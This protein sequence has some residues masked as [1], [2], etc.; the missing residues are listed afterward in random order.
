[1]RHI[2]PVG[3]HEKFVASGQ[4]EQA[5][6]SWSIHQFPDEAQMIRLDRDMRLIDGTSILIEAWRSPI[7]EGGNIERVDVW[8]F[9]GYPHRIQQA[10]ARYFIADGSLEVSVQ[11]NQQPQHTASQ[12]F[13]ADMVLA[14]DLPV[15]WGY[16]LRANKPNWVSCLFDFDDEHAFLPMIHAK[17]IHL[18]GDD[19]V[20][21]GET[22]HP[23]QKYWLD[24]HLV[25]IDDL[26]VVLMYEGDNQHHRVKN[27]A[28]RAS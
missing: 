15:F 3:I 10:K 13:L 24:N 20:Y 22:A 1:M 12:P 9:A 7:A 21:L 25:W 4:Y 27:Y 26:G 6:I 19:V 8:G 2:H 5:H 28:R 16:A 17:T 11:I 14:P 18:L 23:V